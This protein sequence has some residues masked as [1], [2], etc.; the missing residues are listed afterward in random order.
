[1]AEELRRYAMCGADLLVLGLARGGV[2]VAATVAGELRASLDVLVARKLGTPG[3]PEFALGA[4]AA[5][6]AEV[7]LV[8]DRSAFVQRQIP[9]DVFGAI[10]RR[11]LGELRRRQLVYRDGRPAAPITGRAVI[12]ADD[13]LATGSTMRAAVAAVRRQ[14]PCWLVVAVPVGPAQTCREL[15]GQVDDF[16]CVWTPSPFRAVGQAYRDF[17]PTSDAQVRRILAEFTP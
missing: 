8:C 12:L 16:V 10:Y 7:E 13:G 6:G 2:P 17:S 5:V 9:A 4:I 3:R 11:E 14:R 1:V 15:R